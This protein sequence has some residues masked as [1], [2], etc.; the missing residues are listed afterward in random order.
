MDPYTNAAAMARTLAFVRAELAPRPD[1]D[2]YV[3]EVCEE[4]G[5]EFPRAK[6]RRRRWCPECSA[7][8]MVRNCDATSNRN[9]EAYEKVV[10]G[11]CL[12]WLGEANRLGVTFEN[13][14]P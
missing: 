14:Q 4:C 2:R 1:S 12:Y 11:Q 7:A 6:G 3:I 9:G 13:E 5:V 10:R 8:R